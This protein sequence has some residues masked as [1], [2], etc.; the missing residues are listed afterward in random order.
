MLHKD[1]SVT[2]ISVQDVKGNLVSWGANNYSSIF[3]PKG[4]C[5]MEKPEF[6]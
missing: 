4:W 1:R 6:T 5:E 3:G 2:P